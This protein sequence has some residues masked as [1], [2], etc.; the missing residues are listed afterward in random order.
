M[1]AM[2]LPQHL[3][4]DDEEI[5][6]DLRT[7]W[8]ALVLPVFTLVAT[9]A[10]AAFLATL[11]PD[12]YAQ[13]TVRWVILGLAVLVVLVGTVVPFI[14]WH[15][16][17]FVLTNRRL[18][19]RAGILSRHGRDIPLSR[20]NDISFSHNL[21]ERLLGCGTLVIESAGEH[22]RLVFTDIPHVEEVQREL[23]R[24]VEEEEQRLRR[25]ETR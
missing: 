15:T 6:L 21:W 5:E 7:H 8:K 3:L 18:V 24:C 1:G 22:G 14:R 11:V 25:E 13:A 2:S 4:A 16:T 12:G 10:V 20:V 17:S 19:T 9:C 23:Y